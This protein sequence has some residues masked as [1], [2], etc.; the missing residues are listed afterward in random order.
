MSDLAQENIVGVLLALENIG[1]I[2]YAKLRDEVA[3]DAHIHNRKIKISGLDALSAFAL[4][5]QCVVVV[6]RNFNAAVTAF[7]NFINH[8]LSGQTMRLIFRDARSHF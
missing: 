8:P 3:H 2:E 1:Q 5:T 7:I 6:Q 4:G